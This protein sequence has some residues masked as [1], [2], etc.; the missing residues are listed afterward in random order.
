MLALLMIFGSVIL[1]LLPHIP[2]F[3]PITAMGLFG[4]V[5]LNKKFAVLIPL[6]AMVISDYLLLYISP[7]HMDFGRIHPV[8][9]MFHS[10]TLYVWGSFVISSLIGIWLRDHKKPFY[11]FS[12][13][14]LASVQ[15]FIITNFGTW[16]GGMYGRGLEGLVQSYI[17][18]IPFYKWTLM[19]DLFYTGVFFG[20]YALAY[21]V[22]SLQLKNTSLKI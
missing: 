12:G 11:I 22:K 7:Y 20:S 21:K 1:R 14:V 4:G 10:T 16:A 17:M 3:A 6:I 5:Y 9:A 18:A 8:S 19:G 2:N 13:A 15:F